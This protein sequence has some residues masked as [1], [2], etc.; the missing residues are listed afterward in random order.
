MPESRN[1]PRL[2]CPT[3]RFEVLIHIKALSLALK[4]KVACELNPEA[5][6]MGDG[7]QIDP[8]VLGA[9]IRD[10]LA[11][12]HSRILTLCDLLESIADSLPNHLDSQKCRN[13]AVMV[14]PT[15]KQMHELEEGSVFP[16]LENV[17]PSDEERE[18]IA[19]LKAE[20]CEDECYAEELTDALHRVSLGEGEP[21]APET[22]GYMLRGF[23]GAMRRHV[24]HEQ[25]HFRLYA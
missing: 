7:M 13:A 19:R 20:H 23:F 15:I 3:S 21:V 18:V 8:S 10:K 5:A 2:I 1:G 12:S 9:E 4:Q 14:Q 24:A 6:E 22:L 25:A 16:Y 11:Q 17:N